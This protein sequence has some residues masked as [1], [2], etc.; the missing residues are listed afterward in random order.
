[1]DNRFGVGNPAD[2]DIEKTAYKS[3]EDEYEDNN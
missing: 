2:A 1:M 3:T